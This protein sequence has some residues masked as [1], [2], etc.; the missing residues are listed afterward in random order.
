[1]KS[2]DEIVLTS[3][4]RAGLERELAR[5]RVEQRK[6]TERI[7]Q[8]MPRA[9]DAGEI[10]EYLDAQRE[11]E[12]IERRIALLEERLAAARVLDRRSLPR[13]EVALGSWAEL[14]DVD[15]GTRARYEVVSSPEANPTLGR[16]SAESPVGRAILGHH[17]GDTVDVLT[18]KGHRHL[19]LLSVGRS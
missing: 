11:E 14:E 5:L 1:M 3:E 15:T 4:G 9:G 2:M 8:A 10:T 7:S 12:M 16:L 19:K 18:P 6:V 13:H 17:P